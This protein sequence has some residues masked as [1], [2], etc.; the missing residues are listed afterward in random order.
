MTRHFSRIMSSV[1]VFAMSMSLLTACN[2]SKETSAIDNRM[3][4]ATGE[5]QDTVNPSASEPNQSIASDALIT[6][7]TTESTQET[8]DGYV[9]TINGVEYTISHPIEDYVYTIPGSEYNYIHLDE[10]MEAYGMTNFS[11]EGIPMFNH[12]YKNDEGLEIDFD[13][14]NFSCYYMGKGIC[15]YVDFDYPSDSTG[16]SVGQFWLNSGYPIDIEGGVYIV[17]GDEHG[18]R[19]SIPREILVCVAFSLDTYSRTGSTADAV[20]PLSQSCRI[21][22]GTTGAVFYIE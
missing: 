18:G 21:G 14:S 4:T 13:K 6:E 7:T 10:F 8:R 9:Y 5:T 1:V 15:N 2:E 12:L 3:S 22:G 17:N 16:K 20:D 11:P 19:Y